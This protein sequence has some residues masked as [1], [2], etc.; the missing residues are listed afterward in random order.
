MKSKLT[1]AIF[2]RQSRIFKFDAG[3]KTQFTKQLNPIFDLSNKIAANHEQL[4]KAVYLF[5]VF[6]L[7]EYSVK[8]RFVHMKNNIL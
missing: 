1:A 2:K 4:K 8:N 6:Y 7:K 5:Q 3:N